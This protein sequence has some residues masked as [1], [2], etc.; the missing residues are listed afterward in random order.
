MRLRTTNVHQ[1]ALVHC[2]AA[3]TQVVTKLFNIVDPDL[4]FFGSKDYQQWRILHRLARDLDFGIEVAAVPIV[5]E[6]DGLAMSRCAEAATKNA[7]SSS[8]MLR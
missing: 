3:G 1:P 6:A 2:E 7:R 8:D 5:R 4:A